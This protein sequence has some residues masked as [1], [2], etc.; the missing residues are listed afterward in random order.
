MT[1]DPLT[2]CTGKGCPHRYTC[3][4]FL[5]KNKKEFVMQPPKGIE[6]GVVCKTYVPA[7]KLDC[8]KEESNESGKSL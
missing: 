1:L 5:N 7:L 2:R 4:R 3:R 6:D 8:I